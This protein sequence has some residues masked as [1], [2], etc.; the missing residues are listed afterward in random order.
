MSQIYL[1]QDQVFFETTQSLKTL[2]F[3]LIATNGLTRCTIKCIVLT[4]PSL[5]LDAVAL[6]G[7]PRQVPQTTFKSGGDPVQVCLSQQVKPQ[8]LKVTKLGFGSNIKESGSKIKNSRKQKVCIPMSGH[9]KE[10]DE[11]LFQQPLWK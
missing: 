10:L 11:G 2:K 9:L 5:I 4:P 8:V 7:V 1:L 3:N 6:F